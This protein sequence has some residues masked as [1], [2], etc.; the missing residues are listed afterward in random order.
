M[1]TIIDERNKKEEPTFEKLKP[2]TLFQFTNTTDPNQFWMKVSPMWI[3]NG[4]VSNVAL[5][6]FG[7]YNVI[8]A[9]GSSEVSVVEGELRVKDVVKNDL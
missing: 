5:Q 7:D 2:G 9:L 4:L 3:G 8:V 6:L 1:L